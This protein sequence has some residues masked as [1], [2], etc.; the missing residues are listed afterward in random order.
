MSV[1]LGTTP[2]PVT[3]TTRIL[4]ILVGNPYKCSFVTVT[5]WWPPQTKTVLPLFV[6]ISPPG[7]AFLKMIV[8]LSRWDML[9]SSLES[10]SIATICFLHSISKTFA[11]Q[12]PFFTL[13]WRPTAGEKGSSVYFKVI[14]L[15]PK[16]PRK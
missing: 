3:M 13:T 7:K 14:E 12:R 11:Y 6:N 10:N 16:T 15:T 8:L 5:G 1:Y 2:Q 4:P 9:Y